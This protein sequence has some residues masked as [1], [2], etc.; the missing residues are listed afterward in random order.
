MEPRK[1]HLKNAINYLIERL[2]SIE[3]VSSIYETPA[4]GFSST[5]FF[6]L[7]LKITTDID[8]KKA[9]NI[10]QTIEKLVGRTSKTGSAYEARVID[11][12]I[13]YTSEGIF[14]YPNLVI[15][16]P[17]MSLRNF[18]L[19]PLAEIDPEIIHPLLHRST[20]ELLA[21]CT[22]NSFAKVVESIQV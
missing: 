13:I 18:V 7:C 15:P 2:G 6:N 4:W 20:L 3:V 12:D 11:I 9:L 14:N 17:L 22:D 16:H 1:Q 19:V 10:T 21:N 8:T 5:P